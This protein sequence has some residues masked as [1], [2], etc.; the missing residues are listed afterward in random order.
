MSDKWIAL[1]DRWPDNSTPFVVAN[2]E[3][4]VVSAFVMLASGKRIAYWSNEDEAFHEV[5]GATHWLPI[6][7]PPDDFTDSL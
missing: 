3:G 5:A 7:F 6:P 4:A 1:T 2:A